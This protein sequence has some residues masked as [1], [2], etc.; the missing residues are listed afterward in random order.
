MIRSTVVVLLVAALS[1]VADTGMTAPLPAKADKPP[2]CAQ[3]TVHTGAVGAAAGSTY[4]TFRVRNVSNRTCRISRLPRVA[5]VNRFH[6]MIGWPAKPEQSY[7]R[8]L[9][10]GQVAR[11]VLQV[12]NPGNFRPADC[13]AHRA[14]QARIRVARDDSPALLRWDQRV[15]TTRFAR[16]FTRRPA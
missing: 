8:V 14:P 7:L 13:L 3:V 11:F 9:R 1:L 16:S 15:C 10:P 5:Y 12:P 2:A 4:Q 6:H